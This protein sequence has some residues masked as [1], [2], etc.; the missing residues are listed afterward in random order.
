[1][2]AGK[3]VDGEGRPQAGARVTLH[4][5]TAPAD[6]TTTDAS[7]GFRLSAD[8]QSRYVLEAE[9]PAHLHGELQ[10][11]EPGNTLLRLVV[12]AAAAPMTAPITAP[13]EFTDKP[14]FAVAGIT[15][16]TAVG[17]HGSDAVLRTSEDLA[18]G[19]AALQVA[20]S[21]AAAPD[22]AR[23]AAFRRAV[24]AQPESYEANRALGE[25]YLH[26]H[27]PAEASEFL[28]RAAAL[29]G[30]AAVD[31]YQVALACEEE[32]DFAKARQH[33]ERALRTSD[34]AEYHRLAGELDERL[35]EPVSAVREEARA[36]ALEPTEAN[37]FAWGSE[38]LQHRAIWQAEKVFAR[39]A[40]LHPGSQRL[41]T[42]WVA[43]LFG[44]ARYDEAAEHLCAASDLDPADRETYLL[45]GK[46]A[47]GSP[48]V[49]VCAGGKLARF[50]R[51]RP[52]DAEA[53]YYE[54]SLLLKAGDR[55]RAARLFE[56]AVAIQ[57]RFAEAYL[58]IGILRGLEGE[59]AA[60][61]RA[62]EQAIAAD[63]TMAEPHYRLAVLLRRTGRLEQAQAEFALHAQLV[64]GQAEAVER[65]RREVKQ[66]VIAA[67]E[68]S[69]V[70]P[71]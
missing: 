40:E 60:A 24:T 8:R 48:A 23:E 27:R 5:G 7:G 13:M 46:V 30:H 10:V 52:Q 19:T 35:G 15:D 25:F 2:L 53:N 11:T 38:L 9:T 31:E 63:P 65:E 4:A 61:Q 50:L 66:F 14:D 42:G 26:G 68:T 37:Y 41:G 12:G 16:W 6:T 67:G 20:G 33:V 34:A 56:K 62:Y 71:Q 3:V 69:G 43:A 29:H 51:E 57:P 1:M 44:E 18:R 58:Q 21:A 32:G 36:A 47:L 64:Q 45:L 22:P 28:N 59:D 39:G 70:A 54:A 49:P 17:G 55:E